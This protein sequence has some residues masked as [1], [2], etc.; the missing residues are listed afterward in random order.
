MRI[1]STGNNSAIRIVWE[2]NPLRIV[3]HECPKIIFRIL[4]IVTQNLFP[5]YL[6]IVIARWVLIAI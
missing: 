3:Q 4:G 5:P 1:I 6:R 2:R